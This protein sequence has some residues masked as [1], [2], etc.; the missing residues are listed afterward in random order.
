MSTKT[1]TTT[2]SITTASTA[3]KPATGTTTL[4]TSEPIGG[5]E[6]NPSN[7]TLIIALATAIPLGLIAIVG[8]GV[9]IKRSVASGVL[10]GI[11]HP[12][13]NIAHQDE[14][15]VIELDEYDEDHTF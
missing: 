12:F 2:E 7:K 14:S 9:W 11:S 13:S 4:S 10:S 6:D 8:I 3:S 15:N 5:K 1:P